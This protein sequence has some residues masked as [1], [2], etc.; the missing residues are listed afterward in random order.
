MA[1][2]SGSLETGRR[3]MLQIPDLARGCRDN[4]RQTRIAA[5][6]WRRT[7][8]ASQNVNGVSAAKVT[9]AA[10]W[11]CSISGSAQSPPARASGV[12]AAPAGACFSEPEQNRPAGSLSWG[13]RVPSQ[14][15]TPLTRHGVTDVMSN[16]ESSAMAAQH[17]PMAA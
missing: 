3:E 5:N 8:R 16:F 14:I 9:F 1:N 11:G 4:D 15:Q 2:S 13:S 6:I 10:G 17:G 7:K 12:L